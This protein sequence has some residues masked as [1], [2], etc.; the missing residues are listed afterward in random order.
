MPGKLLPTPLTR[1]T[2]SHASVASRAL[3][4]SVHPNPRPPQS[5][6]PCRSVLLAVA[7]PI[8]TPANRGAFGNLSK[9]RGERGKPP[10]GARK[11]KDGRRGTRR[12]AA[13]RK[14]GDDTKR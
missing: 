4:L 11:K 6:C 5:A 1:V 2:V 7:A 10:R 3:R 9:W 8:P 12:P 13:R 14:T